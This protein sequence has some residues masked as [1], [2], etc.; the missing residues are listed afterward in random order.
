MTIGWDEAKGADA[1][2]AKPRDGSD[3]QLGKSAKHADT[4]QSNE[5]LFDGV[6]KSTRELDAPS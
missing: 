6:L 4:K 2:V 3:L 5:C 1:T